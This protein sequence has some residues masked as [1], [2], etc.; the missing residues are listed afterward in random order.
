[1]T[2]LLLTRHGQTKENVLRILQ[3]QMP[4][5][6]TEEGIKQAEELRESLK[7]THIDLI[8]S[9]DLKRAVDTTNIVNAERQLPVELEPLIRERN[10]GIHTGMPYKGI[11]GELDPSAETVE[12]MFRRAAEWLHKVARE[13]EG[14]TVLV[15]SHGLFL[16][17]IQGAFHGKTIRDIVPME[18]AEVRT[19]E[20]SAD[21]TFGSETEEVGATAN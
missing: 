1:M 12:A 17:V 16:R 3:G 13:H 8:I 15:I 5:E 14:Q 9:S 2:T 4:G 21:M 6:L 11:T 18:N 7:G 20:L 10:F 19:I